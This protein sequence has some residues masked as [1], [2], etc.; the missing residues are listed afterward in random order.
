MSYAKF[1]QTLGYADGCNVHNFG[2]T[3]EACGQD[4]GDFLTRRKKVDAQIVALWE[5]IW[6]EHQLW[7]GMGGCFP[8]DQATDFPWTEWPT[9]A[10]Y[11][12]SGFF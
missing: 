4:L 1:A 10:E 5:Q 3:Y 12:D 7:L 6:K 11:A 9:S 2:M 8:P